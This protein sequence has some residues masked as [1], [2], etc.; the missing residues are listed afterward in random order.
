MAHIGQSFYKDSARFPDVRHWDEREIPNLWILYASDVLLRPRRAAAPRAPP[1]TQLLSRSARTICSRSACSSALPPPGAVT[2]ESERISANGTRRD[3]PVDSKAA[4]S[5][6]FC[7]S[8]ILPGH[9]YRESASIV[10]LGILSICFPMRRAYL[11][12]K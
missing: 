7:N 2:P 6:R 11:L 1:T 3:G 4:R 8:R 12:A 5:M 9:A 10:S